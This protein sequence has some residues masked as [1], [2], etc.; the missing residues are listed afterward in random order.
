MKPKSHQN[1][2]SF[3]PVRRNNWVIKV[4]VFKNKNV[5]VVSR[6]YFDLDKVEVYFFPD[7]DLAADYIE[8]L[9][10]RE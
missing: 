1:L 2:V 7:Q 5:L 10:E 8:Q 3:V 4:S 9:A 6:H